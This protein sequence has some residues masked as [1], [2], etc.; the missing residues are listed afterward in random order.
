MPAIASKF[1][2]GEQR[3]QSKLIIGLGNPG[4]KYEQTR[5]NFGFLVVDSV[6]QEQNLNWQT[7][8][9]IL[10]YTEPQSWS[11]DL[12]LVRLC[13]PMTYMNESGIA[14]RKALR[15][16]VVFPADMI[17]IY[18]D[19]D[20]P[21]GRMRIRS[22]GSAGGHKGIQS[23]IDRLGSNEFAR[24]RLGIGPQTAG[25]PA[26]DYVLERFSEREFRRVEEV[27]QVCGKA[28]RDWLRS[29]IDAVM[30]HYNRLEIPN[31]IQAEGILQ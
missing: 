15:D 30:N 22:Q 1:M 3:S 21:L 27:M 19:I 12:P 28:L 20:L 26:E 2:S 9:K 11:P 4:A 31:D 29:D 16:F 8:K 13:K 25:M 5:H 10:H 6:V 14:V 17:V 24:I 23:I 7:A 18:D